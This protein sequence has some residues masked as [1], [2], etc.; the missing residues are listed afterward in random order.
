MALPI[1]IEDLLNRHRI[2]SNRI[3]FKAGWDPADIYQTICAF[4]TDL[5]DTGGGYILI[6]VEQDDNGVAKRPVKGLPSESIDGI[7][8][9]MIGYDAKIQPQYLTKVSVEDVDGKHIVVIWVPTGANRPYSV[10]ECVNIK[11]SPYKF[12]VRSKSSTIEAKGILLDRVRELA[13]KVP[14]DERGNELAS[15]DDI[16]AV[17]VYEHLKTVGSKLTEDFHKHNLEEILE[18]M[19]LLDGP[20]ENRKIKNCALMMFC[21]YPE[22]FFP[23]TQVDIVMFPEGR[24]ENPDLMIEVQPIKGPVP[25]IIKETLSYLNTNVIKKKIIKPNDNEKSISV[26]NYPYQALEET[27]VNALYHR[28]YD[29]REPVEIT[30]E[31]HQIDI[32]SHSGPDLSISNEAIRRAKVLKTRKYRNRRLGDFL[33][34]LNLTEGRATGIPTVQKS[35]RDNGSDPA[36]IET[37]ETRT[38]FLI[39]IPIRTDFE[40]LK[41]FNGDSGYSDFKNRLGHEFVQV[42]NLVNECDISNKLLLGQILGQLYDQVWRKTR[43]KDNVHILVSTTIDIFMAI[44]SKELSANE[45][46]SIINFGSI[47]DFKRKILSP[48]ISFGYIEMTLPDKPRSSKQSYRLTEVGRR[49]FD[50]VEVSNL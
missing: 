48:L 1:N 15:I 21:E 40:T 37:D 25:K 38:Y 22:K 3:E 13:N 7:Q 4:A 31:P 27:V 23:V 41:S 46:N 9:K 33:K 14:F 50:A 12:Y 16:S 49:L 10:P 8:K 28:Q 45:I 11:K 17:L 26:F 47:K 19:N 44:R 39:S 5:E 43:M 30:I 34:E 18:K 24:I 2:E 29:E 35:L 36:V 6:G 42:Q 32:L 20:V